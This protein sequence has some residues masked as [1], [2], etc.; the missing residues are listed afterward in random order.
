M[1]EGMSFGLGMGDP[2]TTCLIASVTSA[3]VW[4]VA[5]FIPDA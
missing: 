2:I 1:N 3:L 4:L 5:V